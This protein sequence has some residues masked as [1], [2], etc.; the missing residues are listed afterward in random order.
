MRI[1]AL[2]VTAVALPLVLVSG[3]DGRPVLDAP[4]AGHR[5]PAYPYV[6][7]APTA[8]GVRGTPLRKP[9]GSFTVVTT[10]DVL[11][12]DKVTQQALVDGKGRPD[13][14]PILAAVKPVISSADLAICHLETPLGPPEGPV[15]G[16][17]PLSVPPQIADTLADL[18]YKTCSTASDH[19]LDQGVAGIDRTLSALD[20]VHIRHT[21]SA[22]T[23]TEAATPDILD[24]RG[25]KVAQLAYTFGFDKFRLPAGKPWL[26]NQ[27]DARRIIAAAHRA[28]QAGAQ[29]VIVSLHW[30]TEYQHAPTSSQV[31]LAQKLLADKD[32]DLVVGHHVH[33][34]QPFARAADGKWVAYG[35][36]NLVAA[37]GGRDKSEGLAA[38]F[39]FTPRAN[40]EWSVS[41]AEFIPLYVD[42]GPPLR[43]L[44][45][46]AAL[47]APGMAPARRAF[48][49]GIIDRTSHIVY[50]RRAL[51]TLTAG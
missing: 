45:V 9:D 28:R 30:G 39:T 23:A 38:R 27:I 20:R 12:H 8:P 43:V 50:S 49:Q 51:P 24:V 35:M 6:Q 5:Q 22:R 10:G 34:V 33:V 3:C 42:P 1:Y 15:H 17:P 32:I 16:H 47:K 36:G 14:G 40:G 37:R 48:L 7:P 21:G 46:P 29:V 25:V 19:T 41:R 26:A 11:L 2:A 4:P 44:D 13:Y 31:T 18:G